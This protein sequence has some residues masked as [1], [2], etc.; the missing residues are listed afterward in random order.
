MYEISEME[1]KK[2]EFHLKY[3][4][5]KKFQGLDNKDRENLLLTK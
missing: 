1:C 4:M 2:G 3:D 5:S